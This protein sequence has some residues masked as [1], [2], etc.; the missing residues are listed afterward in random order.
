V[1]FQSVPAWI[2]GGPVHLAELVLA[3]GWSA[4]YLVWRCANVEGD[5][6]AVALEQ[7]CE[8]GRELT[9]FELLHLTTPDV[10]VVDGE[11]TGSRDGAPVVVLRAVDSTTWDVQTVDDAD[12]RSVRR[13]FPSATDLDPKLFD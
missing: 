8:L 4:R 3:L 11:V 13:A 2:D 5:D 9:T 12:Y 10:Q 7:A 6:D 1:K